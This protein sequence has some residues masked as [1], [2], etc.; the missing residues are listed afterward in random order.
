[1]ETPQTP[2]VLRGGGTSERGGSETYRVFVAG[3]SVP[4]TARAGLLL[5]DECSEGIVQTAASVPPGFSY[6][7]VAYV[8]AQSV[9]RFLAERE[10]FGG[11]ARPVSVRIA[12]A[13]RCRR[14]ARRSLCLC[15]AAR[16]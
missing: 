10:G 11:P 1:M 12:R 4:V 7:T 9:A 2:S 8:Q 16:E 5:L 13:D 6:G 3:R 14:S 15:P